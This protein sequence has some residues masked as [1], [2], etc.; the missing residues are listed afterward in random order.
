MDNWGFWNVR[1]LNKLNKVC[2][3]LWFMKNQGIGLFGLL[4]TKVKAGN[5][6]KVF[7][8]FGGKWSITANY[9][10]HPGGRIWIVW[11][12]DIFQV[13]IDRVEA[14][15]IHVKVVH[16]AS[17]FVFWYTVVYR[18]NTADEREVLWHQIGE[19][20]KDILGPWILGGDFNNVLN[21]K[22]RIGSP[23]TFAEIEKFRQCVR[24]M[25]LLILK[26]GVCSILGIK[27]SKG[28]IECAQRL[29]GSWLMSCG[30]KTAGSLELISCLRD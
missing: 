3:V 27:S 9:S 12:H 5:F 11:L 26:L 28:A 25:L 29:I 16:K 7:T 24:Q 2:D 19:I 22:D 10:K 4:E 20:K 13:E 21:I 23:V 6:G 18:L 17:K 14:Q 15:L 30:L 8:G 1:G